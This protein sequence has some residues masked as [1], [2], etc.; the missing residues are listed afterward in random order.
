MTIQEQNQ[1][2]REEAD[3]IATAAIRLYNAGIITGHELDK[4]AT[5]IEEKLKVII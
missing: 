1:K 5:R 4:L 2:R 3:K